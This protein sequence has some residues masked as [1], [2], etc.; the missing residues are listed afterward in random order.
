MKASE[1]AMAA[2][3]KATEA[4]TAANRVAAI[5]GAGSDSATA[6]DAAADAAEAAADAAEAASM[7]AQA[8]TMCPPDNKSERHGPLSHRAKMKASEA[9]M[10][11]RMK[12]TEARTAANRVAAILGAGSDSA[13][14]ADAAADAAEAAADAAEAASM[15]AQ[16]D[17]MSA[18]AEST[19][20]RSKTAETEQGRLRGPKAGRRGVA[21]TQRFHRVAKQC[22]RPRTCW[23]RGQQRAGQR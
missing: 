9:A 12:A 13:T 18:D 3:M 2:R 14:A 7:R 19:T 5:L 15:R 20:S 16:A 10:A 22:R 23:I 4:R 11:A 1:A 8:D 6:A 17:T 21:G